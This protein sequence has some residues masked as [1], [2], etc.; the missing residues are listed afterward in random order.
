MDLNLALEEILPPIEPKDD[1]TAESPSGA[2]LPT[3]CTVLPA[4]CATLTPP[5]KTYRDLV[6]KVKGPAP[7][8]NAEPMENAPALPLTMAVEIKGVA[9]KKRP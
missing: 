6:I 7:R 4:I 8:R 1:L 2:S 9:I 3:L 5:V